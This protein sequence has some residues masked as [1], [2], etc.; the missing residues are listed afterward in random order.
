[1]TAL[2]VTN[3]DACVSV[4]PAIRR[5]VLA[6]GG[7]AGG[8]TASVDL[9]WI[10][11]GAGERVVRLGGRLFETAAALVDRRAS[12]ELFHSALEVRLHEQRF[13]IEMAPVPDALGDRRGVVAEGAG[14]APWAAKFSI[15][16]Y[17]VRCWR[18][19]Q[20]PDAQS[21]NVI[22]RRLTE[23]RAVVRRVLALLP[24][25]PNAVWGRDEHR[26]GVTWNS[27]SVTAWVLA[28][29]G[30]DTAELHPPGRRRA[31]GWNAG[32]TV[33]EQTRASGEARARQWI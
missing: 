33:A 16:R 15:F 31:P 11:L 25:V 4:A 24:S 19:G 1:M 12:C 23:D 22:S 27:N 2:L 18:N 5:M 13:V 10:P 6:P 9:L 20:I 3:S 30:L 14:V 8:A 29:A 7:V 28:R 32:I 17:E 26:T 21:A